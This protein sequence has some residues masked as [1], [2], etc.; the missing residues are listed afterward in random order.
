MKDT[1]TRNAETGNTT[2]T[3]AERAATAAAH[4]TAEARA[5]FF[6]FDL[7]PTTPQPPAEVMMRHLRLCGIATEVFERCLYRRAERQHVHVFGAT[8]HSVA[9]SRER[10]DSIVMVGVRDL[11][12]WYDEIFLK[13]LSC[14]S[15]HFVFDVLETLPSGSKVVLA[16]RQG[17]GCTLRLG[18]GLARHTGSR[19][20]HLEWDSQ[21]EA[22]R[23]H[24]EEVNLEAQPEL[25]MSDLHN[26]AMAARN[27]ME[28]ERLV[29]RFVGAAATA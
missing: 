2:T 11:S 16:A 25:V 19:I 6:G 10:K 1:T 12:R 27:Q 5:E 17:R 24:A 9:G 8:R 15:G 7:N 21:D 3:T 26:H 4:E 18:A 22:V 14:A 20:W 23:R 13:G 29:K 28:A